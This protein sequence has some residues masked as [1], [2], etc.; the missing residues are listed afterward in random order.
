MKLIVIAALAL[1]AVVVAAPAEQPGKVA[2]I[3]RSGYEHSPDGGYIFNFETDDGTSRNENGEVKQVNDAENKPH[4]VILVRG[5]YSFV[6]TEGHTHS[7]EY[8]ADENGFQPQ[9]DDIPKP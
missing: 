4:N 6:D 9:S 8:V 2:S 7:V 3:V 5:S 1:V